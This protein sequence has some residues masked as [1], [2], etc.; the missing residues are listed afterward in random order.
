MAWH[1]LFALDAAGKDYEKAIALDPEFAPAYNNLGA[2]YYGK[3][4]FSLAVKAYKA[5]IRRQPKLA[6]SY[7]NLGTTY[8]AESKQKQGSEMYRKALEMDPS[9]LG[10]GRLNLVQEASPRQQQVA[11][12][13]SL[14]KIYASEGRNEEAMSSLHQAVSAGFKDRKHLLR[15]KEFATLRELP[16]FRQLL[17]D[18]P[19]Q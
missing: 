17:A 16:E 2:V 4:E 15:D 3:H 6:V 18:E 19:S 8:F 1:H 10:S 14:A 9:V 7:L 11:S 12:A 5:A 13:Y